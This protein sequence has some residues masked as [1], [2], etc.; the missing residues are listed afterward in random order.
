MLPYCRL[1]TSCYIKA[2]SC[3]APCKALYRSMHKKRFPITDIRSS[4]CLCSLR[5]MYTHM[6][7]LCILCVHI[8][9]MYVHTCVHIAICRCVCVYVYVYIHMYVCIHVC[10]Y[11]HTFTYVSIAAVR[12]IHLYPSLPEARKRRRRPRPRLPEGVFRDTGVCEK[13]DR[14]DI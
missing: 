10:V 13:N 1:L 5:S 2:L 12:S 8:L 6:Y 14:R 11:T 9:C 7:V 3:R 4:L